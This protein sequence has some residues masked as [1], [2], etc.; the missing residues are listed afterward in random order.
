MSDNILFSNNASALLAATISS[1]DTVVQVAGGFGA[2]FPSPSSPQIF[3]ATLE[4]DNGNIEIVKC[5]SRTGDNLTVVRAQDGTTAQAFTLNV[6]RV[7]LRLVEI[8]VEEFVQKNGASMTGDLI[9]SGNSITDAVIDG[10]STQ[11]TGGEI[12]NVPVRNAAGVS[13]NE[14]A[15]PVSP[16]RA[17]VGGA[18]IL[19]SGDDIVAE[20]DAA[21]TITLNSATVGVVMDQGGAYLR[22]RGALRIANSGNTDWLEATHNGTDFNFLFTNTAEVNW[23]TLLNMTAALR[24]NDNL[25]IRSVF[26][27]FSIDEQAVTATATTSIDYTAGSYVALTMNTNI[28]TLNL[29]NPPPSTSVGVLRLK[30]IQ[31]ATGGRTIAWP[32]SVKW[33]GGTAPTLSTA[34]NAIDFVD[35]WT[36]DAGTTWYGSY[37]TDWS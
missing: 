15:V 21:G 22:M 10:S 33:P 12:V 36:D 7:E 11:I 27:D 29:N 9:M 18:A 2:N 8:V 26:Q 24:L 1:V 31:D 25:L 6:T 17:T 37:N 23:D 35:L 4:D 34:A 13:T 32:A 14:I 16:G 19:A 30:V 28:T 3:Y 5:T 20:L